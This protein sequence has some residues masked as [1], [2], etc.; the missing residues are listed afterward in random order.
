MTPPAASDASQRIAADTSSG[1][2]QAV[3]SASGMSARLVGVSM[4]EGSNI[5]EISYT[6]N[7]PEAARTVADALRKSYI[8][9][10]LAFRREF[11]CDVQIQN[12]QRIITRKRCR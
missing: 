10:S 6:S 7:S 5:L 11:G 2:T 9:T 3:T 8:D 1:V 4:I 12:H